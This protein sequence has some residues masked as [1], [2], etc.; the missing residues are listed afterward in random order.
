MRE[1][2]ERVRVDPTAAEKLLLRVGL[3]RRNEEGELVETYEHDGS[4]PAS[5]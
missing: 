4:P 3:L 1:L 2:K 5:A